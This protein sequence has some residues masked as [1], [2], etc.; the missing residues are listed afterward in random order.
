MILLADIV[1]FYPNES[2]SIVKHQYVAERLD[3]L[4][5]YN[6]DGHLTN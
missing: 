6:N 1:S 3:I 4:N 5:R 2:Q